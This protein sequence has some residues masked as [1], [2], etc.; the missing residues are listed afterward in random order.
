MKLGPGGRR[1]GS[2]LS[3]RSGSCWLGVG[4]CSTGDD[5]D[6]NVW[7]DLRV[8]RDVCVDPVDAIDSG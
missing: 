3:G 2:R 6:G 5:P 4:R 7:R 8:D 1:S